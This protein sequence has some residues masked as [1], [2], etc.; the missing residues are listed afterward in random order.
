MRNA[1]RL[2]KVFG[3][4]V[5]LDYSWFV[6]FV[7]ITWS[8]AGHYLMENQDWS[9]GFRLGMA[10]ATA[11]L[12]F[13]SVLAHEFGHSLVAVAT[14]VPVQRITLFIFGG[15]AQ[16]SREPKRAWHEFLIAIAGPLV[17]LTLAGVFALLGS[18]GR[19]WGNSGLLALGGWLGGTNLALALFNL[20]PGFPLDGGRVLRA[21]VWGLTGSIHGAT[22]FAG[23]IGQIV[24]WLFILVGIWQNSIAAAVWAV[25]RLAVVPLSDARR[26]LRW[27][28]LLHRG[29]ARA[30]KRHPEYGRAGLAFGAG[31]LSI[32]RRRHLPV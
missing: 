19:Q 1:I 9:P 16:I 18:L 27:L 5:G 32:Q 3:I 25:E 4:E 24:A 23:A 7:L 22:R 30:E 31:R 12:F 20:I 15:V 21:V 2:G 28:G 10:I 26:A 8:L 29:L 14:G 11:L 17:S 6:I 13:G